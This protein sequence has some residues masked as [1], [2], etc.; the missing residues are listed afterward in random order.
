ME[1]PALRHKSAVTVPDIGRQSPFL[2]QRSKAPENA[3]VCVFGGFY[4]ILFGCS[5]YPYSA[6]LKVLHV[7]I[8]LALYTAKV[9]LNLGQ[10][11]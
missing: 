10:L 3:A 9:P 8:Q 11:F 4:V 1:R 6:A 5:A 2:L 7:S